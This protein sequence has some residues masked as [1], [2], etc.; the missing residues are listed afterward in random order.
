MNES[1]TASSPEAV[2]TI[3]YIALNISLREVERD[4]GSVMVPAIHVSGL[5]CP[6]A[7]LLQTFYAQID[8]NYVDVVRVTIGGEDVSIWVDDEGL[9]KSTDTGVVLGFLVTDDEG[10]EYP[11]AGN[12]ILTGSVDDNGDSLGTTF[13]ESDLRRFAASGNFAAIEIEV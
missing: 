8:C 10:R 2:K 3:D 5:Q 6:A 1:N 11:L 7:G 12:L 4:E 9:L 13:S